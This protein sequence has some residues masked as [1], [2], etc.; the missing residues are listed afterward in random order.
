MQWEN[1][2][3]L[4]IIFICFSRKIESKLLLYV[5]LKFSYFI[6]IVERKPIYGLL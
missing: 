4:Q 3:C 5:I 6:T 2:K 1:G